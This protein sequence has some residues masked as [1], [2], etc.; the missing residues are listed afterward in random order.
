MFRKGTDGAC[1]TSHHGAL[2]VQMCWGRGESGSWS[3]SSSLLTEQCSSIA[4]HSWWNCIRAAVWWVLRLLGPRIWTFLIVCTSPCGV[5]NWIFLMDEG[6]WTMSCS[7]NILVCWGNSE[8]L[9][10]PP[11]NFFC[12]VH[13]VFCWDI[14]L[15]ELGMG[16]FPPPCLQKAKKFISKLC[17][18]SSVWGLSLWLEWLYPLALY[19]LPG[20]CLLLGLISAILAIA[21]RDVRP[22]ALHRVR[23]LP[24]H[25]RA[26]KQFQVSTGKVNPVPTNEKVS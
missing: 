12:G 8:L 1:Y 4:L 5:S 22:Q 23:L 7:Q 9:K 3:A 25:L 10:M 20:F 26:L 16:L 15:L 19:W 24:C 13:K 2:W 17:S 6:F 14:D 18:S 11:G 21:S